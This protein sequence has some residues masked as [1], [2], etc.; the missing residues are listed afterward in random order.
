V[1]ELQHRLGPLPRG[2]SSFRS[3]TGMTGLHLP[4]RWQAS[5]VSL[6]SS[7]QIAQIGDFKGSGT[8]DILL[9]DT[10]GAMGGVEHEWNADR[11]VVPGHLPGKSG[12]APR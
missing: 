7:W 12:D 2:R 5:P 9:R 1:R 8:S 6:S 4:R 10:N 3:Q 11:L